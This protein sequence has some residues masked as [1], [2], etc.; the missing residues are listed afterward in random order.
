MVG[1]AFCDGGEFAGLVV[2]ADV[3]LCLALEGVG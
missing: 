2:D 1:F 3:L